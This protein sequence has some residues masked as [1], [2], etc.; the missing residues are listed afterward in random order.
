MSKWKPYVNHNK[1]GIHL[2]GYKPHASQSLSASLPERLTRRVLRPLIGILLRTGLPFSAFA[3][4]ARSVYVEVAAKEFGISGRPTNTSRISMLTGLSRTQV[5]KERDQLGPQPADA[6]AEQARTTPP[7]PGADKVR[8]VSRMLM[9]W[10]TDPLFQDEHGQP[11][12][13]S[14]SGAKDS[15]EVLYEL[16]SGKV[17]PLTT[18]LKELKQVGAVKLSSDARLQVTTR[19]YMPAAADPAA[20]ERVTL[21]IADLSSAACYNL[22]RDP[23]TRSRFERFATNQL[24]PADKVDEFRDYLEEEG[25]AFLER[26]DNWLTQYEG[27]GDPETHV[28]VGVGVY[29]VHPPEAPPAKSKTPKD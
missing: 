8:H 3:A 12:L 4:I 15:F 20:L 14:E 13:L 23:S 28:R 16:Y 10:H 2:L 22:F 6:A 9:A 24:I 7:A 5:K 18:V 1:T 17:V 19:S 27:K 29:Q 11:K 25:Q 21:A 26:A